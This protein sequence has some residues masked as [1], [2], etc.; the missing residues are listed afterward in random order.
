MPYAPINGLQVYYEEKGDGP[1]VL[2]LGGLASD[3][4]SWL[5]VIHHLSKDFRVIAP[6]NRCCGRT[7]PALPDVSVE[8]MADDA[9][10]LLR[11]LEVEKV[12]VVG[13]SM[14]GFIAMTLAMRY[15]HL[16]SQL[17]LEATSATVTA[18]NQ[19][20]FSTLASLY[21]SMGCRPEWFVNLFFWLFHPSFFERE[22]VVEAAVSLSAGYPY[23]PS[24][25][26]FRRQTECI[27]RFVAADLAA[28]TAPTLILS[29]SHD[30]V[31]DRECQ[32][33]LKEEI[34]GSKWVEIDQAGHAVHVDQLQ[35]FVSEL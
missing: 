26:A 1:V 35:L 19:W 25:A 22:A 9:A 32:Q 21:E 10:M 30:L 34:S 8:L 4:Q 7:L 6:D 3:S 31:F 27:G 12:R 16:V 17:V 24:P 33:A 29:G 20:L 13:H 5:T 2:L 28:I 18:R 14:G 11:F 15:P 23:N